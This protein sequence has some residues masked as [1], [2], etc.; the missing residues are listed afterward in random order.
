MFSAAVKQ[1]RDKGGAHEGDV[2]APGLG[3]GCSHPWHAAHGPGS[4]P[5][6]SWCL[7]GP[8]EDIIFLYAF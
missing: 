4:L 8:T 5:G 1:K 2:A 6:P 7:F 3:A